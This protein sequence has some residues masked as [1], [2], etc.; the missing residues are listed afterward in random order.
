MKEDI[1]KDLLFYE[2]G[3]ASF[4]AQ[5]RWRETM[6]VIKESIFKDMN[7]LRRGTDA[8]AA[9]VPALREG[10][11]RSRRKPFE[12]T[13]PMLHARFLECGFNSFWKPFD[14]SNVES[15]PKV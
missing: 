15:G 8:F 5:A 14:L 7:L 10:A 9:L 4:R 11:G 6:E 13:I 12:E 3:I 2:R 1:F